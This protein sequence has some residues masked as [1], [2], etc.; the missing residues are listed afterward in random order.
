MPGWWTRQVMAGGA[1]GEADCEALT[2]GLLAQPAGAVSSLAFLGA[3][4]WLFAHRPTS[5]AARRAMSG[6]AALV[7]LVGIASAAYH[8][9]Q[10]TGAEL[11]HD[12]SIAA[13]MA[14]AVGVP[15]DRGLRGRPLLASDGTNDAWFAAATL[16]AGTTAYLLGRTGSPLCRPDSVLQLHA[17]WHLLAAVS[18]AAWGA[19]LWGRPGPPT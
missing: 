14:V 4:G 6:Y 15:L 9:P 17:V 16:A 8:G 5:A 7:G 12:M 1:L 19:A 10:F 3:A 18:F 2:H 11:L 13:T